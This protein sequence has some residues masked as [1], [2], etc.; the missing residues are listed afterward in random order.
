MALKL[1]LLSTVLTLAHPSW[2]GPNAIDLKRISEKV[3]FLMR[4]AKID[5][6]ATYSQKYET[7]LNGDLIGDLLVKM[8]ISD[9][10]AEYT[11]DEFISEC[12]AFSHTG[13]F[14][15]I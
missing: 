8:A 3:E 2:A 9:I 6:N 13:I 4:T 10:R 15:Q 7:P 5:S 1:C 12:G 14:S 11:L